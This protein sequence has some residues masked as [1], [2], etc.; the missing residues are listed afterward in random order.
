MASKRKKCLLMLA[1]LLVFLLS[2]ADAQPLT[3]SDI[4]LHPPEIGQGE[5]AILTIQKKGKLTPEL[6]WGGKEITVVL[7]SSNGTWIAFLGADLTTA[8]GGY[9]LTARFGDEVLRR[10]IPVVTKDHGIRRFM[11]PKEMEALDP[12]TLERVQEESKRM[13]GILSVSHGQPLWRGRWVRPVPGG[14]VSPFGCKTIINDM[15][16]S[17]HSGVDL[18]AAEGTPIKAANRGRV[19]LVADHFFSGL[20][21]VIDHGGGIH[22]MY[23]HLREISIKAGQ[24]VEKGNFIGLS[25][26]SGRATGPHLHFGIRLNGDRVNPLRLIELSTGLGL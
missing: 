26:S 21:V 19:V 25:G 20:S 4:A 5:V 14:I 6:T 11:V 2:G 12:S 17:P 24:I 15:E 7:D 3:G 23:F 22:S 9:T 1:V 8:P 18:K 13:R 16:R 10:Q